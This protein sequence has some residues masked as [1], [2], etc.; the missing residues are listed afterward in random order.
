VEGIHIWVDGVENINSPL[1]EHKTM[2]ITKSFF[3]IN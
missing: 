1:K 2:H 3:M